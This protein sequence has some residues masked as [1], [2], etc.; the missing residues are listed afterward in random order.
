[1]IGTLSDGLRLKVF[2]LGATVA[3]LSGALGV[4]LSGVFDH[5]SYGVLLSVSLFLA[6]VLGGPAR[7]WGPMVGAAVI[8][9]LPLGGQP[10]IPL[11]ETT[12]RGGEF[13]AGAMLL[14]AVSA[15]GRRP[16]RS[17]HTVPDSGRV[18]KPPA[19]IEPPKLVVEG[20]TKSFGGLTALDGVNIEI[21]GGSVHAVMGPNGSG[22][23]TLLA[24]LSGH[25]FPHRGSVTLDARDI[26]RSP[27]TDRL[28]MGIARTLQSSELFP[29]LTALDHMTAA[30]LVDR[31]HGGFLRAIARTPLTRAEEASEGAVAAQLLDDLGLAAYAHMLVKEM[32]RGARQILTMALAMPRRRVV[33]LDEPSS[34]MS[35]AEMETAAAIISGYAE[36]GGA[37]VVVEHNMRLLRSIADVITVLDHGR[38]IAHGEPAHIY[39]HPDVRQAY[40]GTVEGGDRS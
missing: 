31:T 35:P 15:R 11:F 14:V 16:A 8:S 17:C 28:K 2:V 23:S 32:P 5:R 9:L 24:I 19:P 33:L 20:A 3:G 18:A 39:D 40:L 21:D 4:Q 26:T 1:V 25:M 13:L 29:D 30:T 22:K 38:V 27:A 12:T 34:G 10:L 37:V 36:R 7:L 6:V